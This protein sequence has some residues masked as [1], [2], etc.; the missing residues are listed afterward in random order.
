M[1]QQ[2]RK[3]ELGVEVVRLEL[4]LELAILPCVGQAVVHVRADVVYLNGYRYI[5]PSSLLIPTASQLDP[6]IRQSYSEGIMTT[7]NT[8][9]LNAVNNYGPTKVMQGGNVQPIK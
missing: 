4:G 5:P 7:P 8:F 1:R 9:N 3:Q 2:E 6:M